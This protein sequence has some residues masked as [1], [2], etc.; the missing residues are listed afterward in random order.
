MV[1]KTT[2]RLHKVC[3][4][5][6]SGTKT[7]SMKPM[8]SRS[9]KEPGERAAWTFWSQEN[10]QFPQSTRSCCAMFSREMAG[11][12]ESAVPSEET[13]ADRVVR[14]EAEIL[15]CCGRSC[16]WN[17]RSCTSWPF[18]DDKVQWLQQCCTPSRSDWSPSLTPKPRKAMLRELTSGRIR[19]CFGPRKALTSSRSN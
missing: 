5:V 2:P 18:L 4:E 14:K 11:D 10:F 17:G 19:G 9:T 13:C 3:Q 1:E 16:G 15:G 7:S 12:V 6:L 8:R